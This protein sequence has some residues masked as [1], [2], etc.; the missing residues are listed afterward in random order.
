MLVKLLFQ[1]SQAFGQEHVNK[2][3]SHL[4]AK[5][6][7]EQASGAVFCASE[8]GQKIVDEKGHHSWRPLGRG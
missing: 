6:A 7:L 4:P 2:E 3:F 1:H 5:V 8:P